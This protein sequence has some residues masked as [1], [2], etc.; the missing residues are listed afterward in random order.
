MQNIV[1]IGNTEVSLGPEVLVT[2]VNRKSETKNSNNETHHCRC[3]MI[4]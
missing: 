3:N 4:F 1:G 2:K